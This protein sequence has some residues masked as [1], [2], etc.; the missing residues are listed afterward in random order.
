LHTRCFILFFLENKKIYSFIK[1]S[2][3]FLLIAP[4]QIIGWTRKKNSISSKLKAA[5]EALV[6]DFFNK[7]GKVLICTF[8]SGFGLKIL[9]TMQ[10]L[11]VIVE[12]ASSVS[13][14]DAISATVRV[15]PLG[16]LV[17]VGDIKQL[18]NFK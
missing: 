3:R 11:L 17:F 18:G 5:Y 12:E 7:H 13:I 9:G 1:I 10:F 8:G 14:P 2:S 4:Y 16:R 15:L 6:A